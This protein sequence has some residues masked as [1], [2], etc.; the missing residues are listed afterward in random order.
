MSEMVIDSVGT[1]IW[2]NESGELHR[3]DGPAVETSGGNKF[4]YI[5]DKL[6]REDGPAVERRDGSCDWY[7]KGLRHR[8]GGPA[9]INPDGSTEWHLNGKMHRTDGPAVE[10][11]DG[12]KKWYENGKL[13]REEIPTS[14]SWRTVPDSKV[15]LVFRDEYRGDTMTVDPTFFQDNGTPID[16]KGN[17]MTYLRTEIAYN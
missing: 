3:E 14:N 6:H 5:H 16:D 8:N 12:T 2:R 11:A 17:D 7:F 10:R 9:L 4:W 1:K 15:R 13:L